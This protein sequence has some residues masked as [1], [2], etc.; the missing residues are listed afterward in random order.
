MS[1]LACSSATRCWAI[2]S[3]TAGGIVVPVSP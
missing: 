3:G 1:G 2:G